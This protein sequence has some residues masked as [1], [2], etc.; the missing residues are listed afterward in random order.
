MPAGNPTTAERLA[1][2]E[3]RV[4]R[5]QDD[6][7]AVNNKLD[8]HMVKSYDNHET[9]AKE[10]GGVKGEVVGLRTE[11]GLMTK[12]VGELITEIKRPSGLTGL[13]AEIWRNPMRAGQMLILLASLGSIMAGFGAWLHG[14]PIP[15]IP[16][17]LPG[18]TSALGSESPGLKDDKHPLDV[19]VP[20]SPTTPAGDTD[21]P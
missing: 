6:V 2:T 14:G 16:K 3:E 4:E 18:I 19:G 5:I 7:G 13:L 17:T 8:A 10:L 11:V 9:M 1:V 21:V 15:V 20:T 12:A